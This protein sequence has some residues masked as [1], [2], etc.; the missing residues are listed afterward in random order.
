[1]TILKK[2]EGRLKLPK[3]AIFD[4]DGLLFDTERVFMDSQAKI[5]KKHGY[6]FK[7]EDYI[8]TIGLFGANRYRK[9]R[10]LY[11]SAYPAEDIFQET[12]ALADEYVK[13][14]IP[15]VKPGIKELLV[16]FSSHKVRCCVASSSPKKS[17]AMTVEKGG[18]MRYFD[19]IIG[20]D[21]ITNSKPDPEM[22]LKACEKA[23]AAADEAIVLEDSENG[24]SAAYAGGIPAICIPDMKQHGKDTID[25]AIAL[26]TTAADVHT[27]FDLE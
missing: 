19:F 11:G 8:E 2:P 20:G 23:G 14:N 15:E 3:L 27:L 6:D 4:M 17:I 7:P 13:N 16:F 5:H 9:L 1:M 22:F 24:L 18:L 12:R 26:V 25:K 10:E 21:E